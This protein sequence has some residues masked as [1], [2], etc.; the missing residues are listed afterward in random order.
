MRWV[1]LTSR[2]VRLSLRQP[3]VSLISSA[4]SWPPNCA[5][6]LLH[7]TAPRHLATQG[8][9]RTRLLPLGVLSHRPRLHL[10]EQAVVEHGK[11][12]ANPPEH[13]KANDKPKANKNEAAVQQGDNPELAKIDG[14]PTTPEHA[15]SATPTKPAM[16]LKTAES[17]P[18]ELAEVAGYQKTEQ[19]PNVSDRTTIPEEQEFQP[20]GH[21]LAFSTYKPAEESLATSSSEFPGFSIDV[22]GQLRIKST[23]AALRKNRTA[24]IVSSVCRN[25][26]EADFKRLL[27]RTPDHEKHQ[28]GLLQGMIN[29]VVQPS[30]SKVAETF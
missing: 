10:E 5:D 29:Y 21:T 30:V 2:H 14:L 1:W 25:M 27:P 9:P 19:Y 26:V 22:H 11:P 15:D 20:A 18:F 8:K 4:S 7:S 28:G 12:P 23:A 16:S 17:G 24:L 3:D 6:P 13:L